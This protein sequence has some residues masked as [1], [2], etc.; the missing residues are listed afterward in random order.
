MAL[1]DPPPV[2]DR[3]PAEGV[4][5]DPDPRVA[6]GV[7]VEDGREVVDVSGQEVVASGGVGGEC[8]GVGNPADLLQPSLDQGV[9]PVLDPGGGVRSGR[10]AVRGV[11]L[12][13]PVGGRVV[14]GR[15][16]DAVRE[17]ARA[18]PVVRQDRVR[19]GGG[20]RVAVV[21]VDQDG[22]TVGGQHLHGR[23]PGGF[24]QRV[25]VGPEEH[26]PVGALPLPVVADGL[27]GGGD[28]V[29]VERRRERRSAVPR[30]SE[31]HTLAGLGRVRVD[32]VIGRHQ[33]CH[34]H[35]V[36][37]LRRLTGPF[38][39]H[40]FSSV[41]IGRSR[42]ATGRT[43]ITSCT[44]YCLFGPLPGTRPDQQ[45]I[46][47]TVDP[48]TDPAWS[49]GSH[50]K[51]GEKHPG[52]GK[53]RVRPGG[54]PDRPDGTRASGISALNRT[55]IAAHNAGRLRASRY[56]LHIRAEAHITDI[57]RHCAGQGPS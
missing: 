14:R 20:G 18:V 6:Y 1:G 34:V 36:S 42:T 12:E 28:V 35:Q 44:R 29:L 49:A 45:Y 31:G 30:G 53:Y 55:E 10:P 7:Q 48:G 38:V 56:A 25:G 23:D 46:R 3:R 8:P 41:L 51:P 32:G 19:D 16:D 4:G 13:S 57:M 39:N 21:A 50:G 33:P 26:G 27:G 2:R 11:V 52:P 9:G 15:D 40:R 22:G 5:A 24:G 37:G 43:I 47:Q 17:T 54:M